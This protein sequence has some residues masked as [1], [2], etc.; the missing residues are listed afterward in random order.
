MG[1]GS[2]RYPFPLHI[3]RHRFGGQRVKR[4]IERHHLLAFAAEAALA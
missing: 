2:G 3:R 1:I 4:R